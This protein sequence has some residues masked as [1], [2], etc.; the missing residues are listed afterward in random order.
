L[1]FER[2]ALLHGNGC[3]ER[4]LEMKFFKYPVKSL[5]DFE[6]ILVAFD[7]QFDVVLDCSGA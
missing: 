2:N 6:L 5:T 1:L 4:T 7:P 3:G